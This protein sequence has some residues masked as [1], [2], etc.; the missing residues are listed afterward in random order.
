MNTI[1][2]NE[3]DKIHTP[4]G[5]A[6]NAKSVFQN[7]TE[8]LTMARDSLGFRH[9]LITLF[10]DSS[11]SITQQNR[12]INVSTKE[13]KLLN[14]DPKKYLD[15]QCTDSSGHHIFNSIGAEIAMGL[16][17]MGEGEDPIK[18]VSAILSKWKNFWGV[19][20]RE[21]LSLEEQVGLFGEVYFLRYWLLPKFGKIVVLSWEGPDNARHDFVLAD[22]SFEVKTSA[23]SK[24]H[25]HQVNSINQL[26]DPQSGFLYLFSFCIR[27]NEISELSLTSII[28]ECRNFL[29]KDSETLS[30]FD[31]ML[32]KS[33]YSEFFREDYGKRRYENIDTELFRVDYSFPKITIESFIQKPPQEIEQIRYVL[34]LN[35]YVCNSI[36]HCSEE[37][38]SLE[39]L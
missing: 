9:L 24:G 34:N 35:T 23:S 31:L 7:L 10:T 4:I 19:E 20:F 18:I 26:A 14:G 21:L 22:K 2:E 32:G 11:L 8:R 36:C 16:G 29:G 39:S 1:D 15:L 37:F 13:L 3:W 27:E 12:G 5:D 28:E 25:V 17:D 33:G 30:A 6:L 38:I